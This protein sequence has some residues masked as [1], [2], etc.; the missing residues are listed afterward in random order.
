M[1][2]SSKPGKPFKAAILTELNK[3]FQV[4]TLRIPDQLMIGQVLVR[5]HYSG[6]CGAQLGEQ[7]GVKGPDK[8]L[9]HC[10]GHEG[11]G[12][13]AAIGPGVRKFR[14]GDSVVVHWKKGT[15]IEA[16]FPRYWC[17]E[18]GR[19][20]GGG[21][22]NT[23]QEFSVVSENRLTLN[24]CG[25][26]HDVAALLGCAVTTGLGAVTNDAKVKIGES[27]VVYGCGGVGLNVIQACKLAG[28]YPI[29]G[30][31]IT[32]AKLNQAEKFGA[33]YA[34]MPHD[35]GLFAY[36]PFDVAFDTTGN[37]SIIECAW[38]DAKRVCL[39]AQMR[40]DLTVPLQTTPMTQGRTIFGT[41]GGS[42]DP[43]T[44]IPRYLRLYTAGKL[45]LNE[46]ITHRVPLDRINDVVSEIRAGAVGRALVDM[47]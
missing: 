42:T 33:D 24:T 39:V 32:T 44:D 35:S 21:S 41:D 11:G 36:R 22:N 5:I 1:D 3:P 6:I 20:I 45:Q 23:W 46:L 43:T 17:D 16:Q 47:S 2:L 18:L 25:A 34:Y 14:L 31:D 13:V 12:T 10:V 40:H 30:V 15:G 8:Y 38:K 37:P 7:S 27:V 28:A 26:P 9:P 29:V 19:E 4:L